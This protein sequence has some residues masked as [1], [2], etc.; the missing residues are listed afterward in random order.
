[1]NKITR[2][3]LRKLI[4]Y[5]IVTMNSVQRQPY[6]CVEIHVHWRSGQRYIGI[7]F[8]KVQ[9]PDRWN[10]E[11]GVWLAK[12]KAI[13]DVAKQIVDDIVAREVE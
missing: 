5:S 12:E 2:E 13:S 7:G 1:M 6:T 11:Y 10:A 8:A 4:R 3:Q 9:W